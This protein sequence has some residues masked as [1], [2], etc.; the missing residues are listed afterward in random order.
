MRVRNKGKKKAENC[1]AKLRVIPQNNE[2]QYPAIQDISLAWEGQTRDVNVDITLKK[3]IQPHGEELLH[4]IFS[5][6]SFPN[7]PA[8]PPTPIHAAISSKEN[9]GTFSLHIE[10]GLV[11]G[12]YVVKITITSDDTHKKPYTAFF[13][14]FVDKEWNNLEMKR[15]SWS[16]RRRVKL[17]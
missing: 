7:V 4:V 13:N 17:S 3:D 9:L 14:V 10:Q 6:S 12:N 8:D 11:V 5:D 2:Q 15:L 1:I 16:K